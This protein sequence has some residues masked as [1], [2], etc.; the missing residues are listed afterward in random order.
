MLGYSRFLAPS[1]ALGAC[2]AEKSEVREAFS[3][4][5]G[6]KVPQA[7]E[8]DFRVR[9]PRPDASRPSWRGMTQALVAL[10]PGGY[11]GRNMTMAPRPSRRAIISSIVARTFCTAFVPISFASARSNFR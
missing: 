5:A 3:P 7:D 11:I 8:G 1:P 2:A 9:Q 10:R 6:E 4:A